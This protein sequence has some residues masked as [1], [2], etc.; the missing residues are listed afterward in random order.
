MLLS[1]D[2]ATRHENAVLVFDVANEID[3]Q[4]AIAQPSGTK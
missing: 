1:A 4:I 2:F 3:L